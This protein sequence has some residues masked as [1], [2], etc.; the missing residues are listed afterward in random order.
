MDGTQ[1]KLLGVEP[2]ASKDEIK[3]AYRALARKLHPDVARDSESATRFKLISNAYT[4]L[5]N[6]MAVASAK[7]GKRAHP[8]CMGPHTSVTFPYS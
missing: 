5:Y 3:T 2:S 4:T 8:Y 1:Y 6:G 7:C